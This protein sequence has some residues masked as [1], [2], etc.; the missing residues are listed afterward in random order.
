MKTTK[1]LTIFNLLLL[2]VQIEVSGQCELIT[3]NGSNQAP[4]S[5]CA[6]V[7][8]TM[9]ANY[10]FMIPVDTSLV[11]ILFVWND[12]TG[13]ETLVPGIWNA[14][15][16]SVW[17]FASH[18]YLPTDECSRTAEAILVYNG[19]ECTSSGYQA[20]IFSTWGTDEENSGVLNTD[21]VVHYVCEGDD[22]VDVVFD[23][24][25]TFN[26]NISIE[27]DRPNRY[28][29]W[30]QFVYNTY[31]QGGDRIPDVTIRDT[32][33]V[34]HNMTD[35][36]G[37]F[38][39]DFFGPVVRIPIPAD[40]P[41]QSS[42]PISA[43]AGGVAGDIFEI[44]LRNWNVCNPYDNNPSDGIDP[45]DPINGDNPPILTTARIE[46]VAPPPVVVSDTFEFCTG[47]NILLNASAGAGTVRWYKDPAMDTFLFEGNTYNPA[48]PPMSVNTNLAGV[49]TFYVTSYEGFCESAP[50]QVTLVLHQSPQAADAGPDIIICNDSVLLNGNVPTAGTGLWSTSGT[51]IISN[52]ANPQTSA[53]NLSFGPNTF[54][55][56]I[57]NGPCTT[58][59]NVIVISDR[60]P[61]PAN[62]GNDTQ[63]CD[64]ASTNL[65][66]AV[67]DLNG[68]GYWDIISGQ[69]SIS[70]STNPSAVYSSPGHGQNM[71]LWRVSSQFGVC[72]VTTDTLIVTADFS[73][74]IANAGINTVLCEQSSHSLS[75]NP[76]QN[77][78]TG[79]WQVITG[80]GTINLPANSN[81][82][83][84]SLSYGE[85]IVSWTLSSL[86]GICPSNSDTVLIE[87]YQSPGLADAGFDKAYCLQTQ[88]T[89]AANAPLI[90]SGSWSVIENPSGVPPVF[91][92]NSS[93]P[94]A[95]FSVSPGNEGRY[96][97]VWNMVN[98]PC[99]SRDTVVI[100][101]GVPVPPAIAGP[102]TI[103]CGYS[104][105]MQGNSISRGLGT[106]LLIDG[107]GTVNY[108]PDKNT[109]NAIVNFQ[110]G[111]EGPFQFEWKLTS[112]SCPPTADSLTVTIK[113]AP[114]PPIVP[115]L[116][117]CGPDSF[118]ILLAASDPHYEAFW[119]DT[120]TGGSPIYRGFE[121][122]TGEVSTTS[123]LYVSFFDNLTAC[124]SSRSE[125]GIVID[126][127]PALPVLTSDTLCGSGQAVLY[128]IALPPAN[129]VIWY[130]S[131]TAAQAV[132]TGFVLLTD[133]IVSDT[134]IFARAYNTLTG[135]IGPAGVTNIKVWPGETAPV[136]TADSGCGPTAFSLSA[137]RNNP[138]N[139][140]FWY[141]SDY[142]LVYIGDTLQTSYIDSTTRFYVAEFNPFTNCLSPMSELPV[143][144]HPLPPMPA[145]ENISHCGPVAILLSPE[146]DPNISEFRWYNAPLAGDLLAITDTFRTPF[147]ASDK[148]YWVSGHNSATG[149]EGPLRELKIEINPLPGFIDILGPTVVLKN[150]SNVMFFTINGR[151]G[152]AYFWDIP[153]E[154]NLESNM[155]DFVRLGFPDTG[156]FVISVY[157]VTVDGCIGATV[158]H[159]I[160]VISDSM[161]VDIGDYDQASCTADAFEIQPWL[162]GGT[163]PYTFSWTGDTEYLTS[164]NTLFTTF[165]P[166]GTGDYYLYLEV[167]D[168]N[169][170]VVRDSLHIVVF[171]SPFT[172]ISNTDTIACV[173]EAYQLLTTNTGSGPFLHYWNGPVQNL[174]NY[175]MPNPVFTARQA[176]TYTF[177]H[178]LSDVNGC[179]AV[180]T[181]TLVSDAPVAGFN[182]LTEP[183]C[184]PLAVNFEN[185]SSGAVS[186][187]WD[188]GDGTTTTYPDPQHLFINSTPEIKY[189]EV[190]LTVT[191]RLGCTDKATNFVM[192]WPNPT[193][194]ITALP[195]TSCS[196]AQVMLVSTPGN[197]RYY[198]SFGDGKPDTVSGRFSVYHQFVNNSFSDKT[199]KA[200]VITQSSLNCFDTAEV[201]IT[202]YATPVASFEATPLEQMF[203][204]NT[205]AIDN[206]TSG[207]W[208]Y[209]WDFGNGKSSVL[210]NPG[211]IIYDEP[212]YYTIS[213]RVSG[214]YCSDSASTSVRL[215]PAP[216]VAAFKGAD[217]GCMP[218]TITLINESSYADSYLWDFGDGS[219]STAK[220]PT[221]T[222][223]Q[224]GIYKIKLTVNG[225]GGVASFSDTARVHILPNSFFDLAPRHVYVNDQPVHYFNLS[226]NADVIEWDFGDGSTSAEHNPKHV[227]KETGTYDV[228]LKVWTINNCFD[229]YV[230]ENAV[231]AQPSGIVEFPNAFRPASPLDENRVFKPGIIDHVDDYHLM[232]FNRWGELIFESFDQ[233]TG[234]DGYY[235]GKPAKQDVY[236]WKVKGTYTDGKGFIKTGNVTLL[237]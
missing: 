235:K 30:V 136:T 180:D 7:N 46:I 32:G 182:I 181:I 44:T 184:S 74:G 178:I 26:C 186:Y 155:N 72:P 112:G 51:A 110:A 109:S 212:G 168:I 211:S 214:D 172:E 166:P 113:K 20:Q 25:S 95:I 80:S 88:D 104:Y 62:A 4:S 58:S 33:G 35:G 208:R 79:L 17:G 192:V 154:I 195:Q 123:S 82:N 147:L 53:V 9:D 140:L 124:E 40:G 126:Q 97:L 205:F 23:D 199:Y 42:L 169:L 102:D 120:L 130:R 223:Y 76:P 60:Q 66:A 48:M 122:N 10:Q 50:N 98:G 96:E 153:E 87:R 163:P 200:R 24:N 173:D 119:Y 198:W 1:L 56:T 31:E 171:E 179:K 219:I 206:L 93:V 6:P 45:I 203:P 190:S 207:N 37:L 39:D 101:F 231:F 143:I 65:S 228:T 43:P 177:S 230:M 19:V 209:A 226:D 160:R 18:L 38:L 61:G 117:S 159:G 107:P 86:L 111:T 116:Q 202:V 170:K 83:I 138:S 137:Q 78:G 157:E 11:Q 100:D 146:P 14:A 131:D 237:Y 183:G 139:S 15:H 142:N 232:I 236:I 29:R 229:L 174:S 71:L 127:V 114:M 115:K 8:F 73:A 216:P 134:Q 67:P 21:P 55:W 201:D 94:G 193:A 49:Y 89:L 84:S 128:A 149:C 2:F 91:S 22:I 167:A 175:T 148:S 54:T 144:I 191:S 108:Q 81:A 141:D 52:P 156:S 225:P 68:T 224:S 185:T 69:G 215:R 125:L 27:P 99:Y 165:S 135:C 36:L 129:R 197:T 151:P 220:D 213:L 103:T 188:F 221:Y 196:P 12:G 41:N 133:N 118:T 64:I 5:V 90:G 194:E 152:S 59:D 105:Q 189:R 217:D 176:G 204:E 106:W 132:D 234:W 187:R 150:Q 233:E 47:D 77:S 75:G 164:A 13:A 70:D 34:V 218:H 92:P 210:A 57:T 162:F 222:Y 161:S 3:V 16:D 145:T 158:Y 227:Y 63:L 28:Y 121:F 85:N